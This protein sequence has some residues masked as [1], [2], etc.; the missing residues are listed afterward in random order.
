MNIL[1]GKVS[2]LRATA[3]VSASSGNSMVHTS[4]ILMFKVDG[5]PVSY[6][7]PSPAMI[8]DGDEVVLGGELSSG[9]F[10]ALAYRNLSSGAFG[11]AGLFAASLG[12][13]ICLIGGAFALGFGYASSQFG[14][15]LADAVSPLIAAIFLGIGAWFGRG[16]LRIRAAKAAVAAAV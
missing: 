11:N 10:R 9:A 4:H 13:I 14:L 8:E 6:E 5:K 16:L 1:K 7:A 2:A 15:P 3:S 12:T